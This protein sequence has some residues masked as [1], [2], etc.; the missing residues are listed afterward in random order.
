VNTFEYGASGVGRCVASDGI[1]G[2][3][4]SQTSPGTDRT[5]GA[6]A[7]V[8]SG[9]GTPVDAADFQVNTYT[10][11]IGIGRRSRGSRGTFVVA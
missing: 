5:D 6:F 10:T 7:R 8:D 9:D 1:H 11:A 4:E 3:L 2:G